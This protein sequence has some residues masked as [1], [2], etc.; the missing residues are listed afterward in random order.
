MIGNFPACDTIT[1]RFEGGYVDNSNDPGGATNRGITIDTLSEARG[2]RVTKQDVR[3]LTSSEASAIYKARYWDT[4]R[5]DRIALGLDLCAY[6]AAVNS[7]PG[8]ALQWLA[9]AGNGGAVDSIHAYSQLR[10][11]F[12]QGLGTW[13]V[14]GRGW[15]ARVGG[16]ETLAMRMALGHSPQADVV[17]HHAA[18]AAHAK[19]RKTKAGAG[20]TAAGAVIAAAGAINKGLVPHGPPVIVIIAL[21]VV[22]LIAAGLIYLRGHHHAAR[23]EALAAA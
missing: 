7:G 4:I 5:A 16:V 17:I 2:H 14:F 15:G 6:D 11:S 22:A 23:A 13:R 12:L 10:L 9:R 8:R 18:A 21:V 1:Q 3:D 20:A 19:A